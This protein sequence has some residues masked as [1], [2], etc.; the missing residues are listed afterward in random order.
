MLQWKAADFAFPTPQER[1]EALASGRYVPE[2][3]IPLD[4]DVDYSSK[5]GSNLNL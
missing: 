2:N 3:C 1:Q 4:M 5:C